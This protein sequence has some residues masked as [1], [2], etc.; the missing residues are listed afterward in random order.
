MLNGKYNQWHT[1]FLLCKAGKY[2]DISE[3]LWNHVL[4]KRSNSRKS[5]ADH[6]NGHTLGISNIKI[7]D[8]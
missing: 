6:R 1:T 4:M 5:K 7:I 2:T 8:I 3:E